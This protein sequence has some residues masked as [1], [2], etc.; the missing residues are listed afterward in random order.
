MVWLQR[1]GKLIFGCRCKNVWDGTRKNELPVGGELLQTGNKHKHV[2]SS[3]E[4]IARSLWVACLLTGDASYHK[5]HQCKTT[6]GACHVKYAIF[7]ESLRC[8]LLC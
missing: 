3:P 4:G 8:F 6:V 7:L 1:R 5:L 2:L